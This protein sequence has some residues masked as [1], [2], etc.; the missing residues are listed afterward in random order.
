MAK[1]KVWI[2]ALKIIWR[3][4][5]FRIWVLLCTVGIVIGILLNVGMTQLVLLVALACIGLG[6]ES[7]NTAIETLLDMIHPEYSEKVKLVK[8]AYAS[9]PIFVFS[10]Y[11][12][13]WLILVSPSLVKWV[14]NLW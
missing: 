5:S 14:L 2:D 12:I 7:A 13:S 1:F 6:M 9:V 3:Q 11:V 4:A 8:D 10:A